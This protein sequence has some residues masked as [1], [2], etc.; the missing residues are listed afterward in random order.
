MLLLAILILSMLA[1]AP[2]QA[3]PRI[4]GE[5]HRPD[6]APSKHIQN[7]HSV[8]QLERWGFNTLVEGDLASIH[9][10][11]D[12]SLDLAQSLSN[13][14]SQ[15]SRVTEID[16][17][18]P[19]AQRV[20]CWQSAPGWDVVV[21]FRERFDQRATPPNLAEDLFLWNAPLA[22]PNNPTE[23]PHLLTAIGVSRTSAF[24][25]PMYIAEV[26]QDL[27]LATFSGLLDIRPLPSW[28]NPAV[29]HNVRITLSQTYAKIEVAQ[30]NHPFTLAL[31]T[32]LPHPAEPLGFEF[33]METS[34]PIVTADGLNVSCL[35]IRK[36]PS[37]LSNL[38]IRPSLC[39]N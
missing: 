6:C 16:A 29:W 12:L 28:L 36:V 17:G 15:V 27:D 23:L 37:V 14:Q 10:N 20:K 21:E 9:F 22:S 30:G 38:P 39:R 5:S 13:T 3:A 7:W 34:G 4:S 26:V 24:G 11:G 2:T 33:S 25:A 18:L 31:Q 19:I 32:A 1:V 35:D 8:D